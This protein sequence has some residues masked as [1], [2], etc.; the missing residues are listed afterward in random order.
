MQQ[1]LKTLWARFQA[2]FQASFP[3]RFAARFRARRTLKLMCAGLAVLVGLTAVAGW[4]AYRRIDGNIRTDDAT[5]AALAEHGA[6]RPD[7]HPGQAQNILLLGSDYRKEAGSERSDTVMLLHLAADRK[8]AEVLSVPRDL[9]VDMPSCLREDGSRSR[10]QN[11]Q[12][13]WA[14]QFGG[15]ACTI[16]TLEKLTGIRID[17]HLIVDFKGFTKI[18]NA[19]GGVEVDVKKA[20][21]DPNVGLDLSPGKHLLRGETALSYVRAR[22]YV[23]DGSDLNRI[24]RQQDFVNRL[25]AKIRGNGT[26]TNPAR[27]YPVLD[28]ATASLTAD[29]GLDSLSELYEV[30]DSLRELPQGALTFTTLPHHQAPDHWYRLD[31]EQP[32]ARRVFDAVKKDQ[33][34]LAAL[35]KARE[36]PSEENPEPE[37]EPVHDEYE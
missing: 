28:A 31:L 1:H 29:S 10:A 3:A 15:A 6:D 34:V 8:R 2:S 17:H 22:Q 11:A 19:V 23:G 33:P 4:L 9:R 14:F 7:R 25:V 13:N 20:E 26:L 18:V 12:F 30:A 16:R 24:S 27:L 36:E 37:Y 5:A 32:E 21:H 35:A